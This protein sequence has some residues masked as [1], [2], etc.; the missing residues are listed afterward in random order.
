M[1][2]EDRHQ[3]L[4]KHSAEGRKSQSSMSGVSRGNHN[5][6]TA[7]EYRPNGNMPRFEDMAGLSLTNLP[8]QTYFKSRHNTLNIIKHRGQ[9]ATTD[10]Y[11][12]QRNLLEAVKGDTTNEYYP[13]PMASVQS[14]DDYLS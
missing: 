4:L 2:A 5:Q 9:K 12:G 1:N 3:V 8:K 7:H 10:G 11:F 13:Q 6:G 14:Q